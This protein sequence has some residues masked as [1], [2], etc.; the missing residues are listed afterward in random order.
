MREANLMV[1]KV[2]NE[3]LPFTPPQK[4]QVLVECSE[5]LGQVNES[6]AKPKGRLVQSKASQGRHRLFRFHSHN[7]ATKIVLKDTPSGSIVSN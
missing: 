6:F 2:G 5:I 3:L 4:G 7:Y 1:D